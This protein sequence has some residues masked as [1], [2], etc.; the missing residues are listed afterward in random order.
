VT[1]VS[2]QEI[3]DEWETIQEDYNGNFKL[4][5]EYRNPETGEKVIIKP[6]KSYD[7][8]PGFCNSHRV[9]YTSEDGETETVAKG[10]NGA[11]HP[12][13]AKARAVSKMQE[14]MA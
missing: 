12:E 1:T 4:I 5:A 14:V 11:E 13:D 10:L 3:P 9:K 2:E 6:Y 7:N 8:V